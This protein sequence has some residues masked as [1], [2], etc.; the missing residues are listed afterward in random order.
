MFSSSL[1][2]MILSAERLRIVDLS[3]TRSNIHLYI[4]NQVASSLT[5]LSLD[6]ISLS[7]ETISS[8]FSHPYMRLRYLSLANCALLGPIVPFPAYLQSLTY[9]DLTGNNILQPIPPALM[10]LPLETFKISAPFTILPDNI[11][12]LNATIRYLEMDSILMSGNT[13]P[14]SITALEKLEFLVLRS[15]G[16]IGPIPDISNFKELVEAD[17]SDNSL[18][19]PIPDFESEKL[20]FLNIHG[21]LLNGTIPRRTASVIA[22]LDLSYNQFEGAIDQDLFS[23]NQ[24]LIFLNLAQNRFSGPLPRLHPELPPISVDMTS[25]KFDGEVPTSYCQAQRLSLSDNQLSGSPDFLSY[26]CLNLT[27]LALDHNG[28]VGDFN[29]SWIQ[30]LTSLETLKLAHNHFKGALPTLPS[31]VKVFD[32][33]YNS[34]SSLNIHDWIAS[35]GFDSLVSLELSKNRIPFPFSFLSLI[36]PN[37]TELAAGWN[38][39]LP[40]SRIARGI[41]PFPKLISLDIRASTSGS[42][43]DHLFPSMTVLRISLNSF[44]GKLDLSRLPSITLLDMSNNFF[45]FDVSTFSSLRLLT[46]VSAQWNNLYG[47]L[48]LKDLPNLQTAN[49]SFNGLNLQPHLASIGSLFASSQLTVLDITENPIPPFQS[50]ETETMGLA[51]TSSSE[52]LLAKP[53]IV[54]C[55]GLSFY[56]KASGSFI[57]DTDLF[58][59]LQCDCNQ[60]HF[61]M[62]PNDCIK[63]P[64]S[65]TENCHGQQSNVSSN[66]Y[67]YFTLKKKDTRTK[68]PHLPP[69]SRFLSN[70]EIPSY[71]TLSSSDTSSS[72]EENVR[73]DLLEPLDHVAMETESCLVKTVQLLSQKSNCQGILLTGPNIAHHNSSLQE[74]LLPQCREGSDGRLC[75]RCV[76]DLEKDESCFFVE[77]YGCTRCKHTFHLSTSIPL[78]IAA[79]VIIIAVVSA[80]TAVVLQRKRIQSLQN[81]NEL[82]TLKRILYR[83]VYLTSLG[84]ISI[85]ITFLQMLLQF[86][87]WEAYAQLSFLRIINGDGTGYVLSLSLSLRDSCSTLVN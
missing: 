75:S 81:W 24:R 6:D 77:G 66:Y 76:C 69:P 40:S 18:T 27:Y 48:V 79:L 73:G 36:G 3:F 30:G 23:S 74:L 51:R 8:I 68:P 19:G 14:T 26:G 71:W 56:G 54:D 60:A 38:N 52:P 57:F 35:P 10:L 5:Y 7:G 72:S 84:N 9:L 21:N 53:K 25:N 65:G 59:F 13:I 46:S 64:S 83:L 32:A 82:S 39:F 1:D 34:F 70:F 37:L 58:S 86:T 85:L 55:H 33:S 17:L 78:A 43:P 61:G 63:C 62:P 12:M 44:E 45:K 11:G 31:N 47:T 22:H 41:E 20:R 4:F 2:G 42:F 49:F 80:V 16:L 67:A 28:F 87:E 15:G 50:I 29:A